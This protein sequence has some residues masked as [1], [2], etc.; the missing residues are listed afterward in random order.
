[1]AKNSTIRPY[2]QWF[3]DGHKGGDYG[4]WV[5]DAKVSAKTHKLFDTFE[6]AVDRVT[7]KW[8]RGMFSKKASDMV[9][10]KLKGNWRYYR[11]VYLS[12]RAHLT[13]CG[14]TACTACSTRLSPTTYRL[15][16]TRA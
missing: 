4:G 12:L 15:R 5:Q 2:R 14:R 16:S 13:T 1:M 8:A 7:K 3:M 6:K 10:E 11:A 9:V